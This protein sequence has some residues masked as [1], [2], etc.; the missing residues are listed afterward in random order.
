MN[1]CPA[2]ILNELDETPIPDVDADQVPDVD[3]DDSEA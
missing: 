1:F 3:T 2:D